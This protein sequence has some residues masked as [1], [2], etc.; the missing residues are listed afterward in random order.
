MSRPE[1]SDSSTST[2]ATPSDGRFECGVILHPAGHTR[3]PAM[4]R[5]AYQALGLDGEYHAYDV[6]PDSL[7]DRMAT[8][9]ARGVHQ[10]AVSIPHKTTIMPFADEV[11]D[12]AREI[13]AVNTITRV[14]ERFVATNT[15]WIG[16]LRAL[17]RIAPIRGKRAAV[18]GAGGTARAVVYALRRR[19]CRVSVLN[20]TRARAEEIVRTLGAER[21]GDLDDL[22]R[23]EPEIVV[24]TTSVGLGER[25]SPVAAN[26]FRPG[27]IVLDVVYAPERTQ[28]REDAE[29]SGARTVGGKWMLVHQ[30][31]EQL[32]LLCAQ[33]A[34]GLRPDQLARI[35]NIMAHA[36]DRA[37]QSRAG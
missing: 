26:A 32:R 21:A 8:L 36:F 4:H 15:D 6:P 28:L 24:N 14:A 25:R 18:L 1:R 17:E 35:P 10:L 27:Q 31:D 5:A 30:A 22:R 2:R 12:V 20:R 11:E 19:E 7:A 33:L 29:K 9:R 37:D 34:P 23:L 3:S 16:A 13:G